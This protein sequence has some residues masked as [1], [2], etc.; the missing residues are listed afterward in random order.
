MTFQVSVE[1]FG[2]V[3]TH[4]LKSGGENLPVTNEN[5]QG[6]WDAFGA[7][8]TFVKICLLCITFPF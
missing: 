1:E 7:K 8:V 6:E 4:V 5:R 3:K 2:S